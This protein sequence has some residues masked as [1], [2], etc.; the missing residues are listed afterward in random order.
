MPDHLASRRKAQKKPRMNY[1]IETC[2]DRTIREQNRF[3]DHCQLHRVEMT[4]FSTTGA[5]FNGI[6]HDHDRETILFG[7][8]GKNATPR[9]IVK[10]FVAMIIPREGINLFLEYKGLGT[11]RSKNRKRRFFDAVQKLDGVYQ[12]LPAIELSV[13]L[14]P[15]E[16]GEAISKQ[17]GV[18]KE[19]NGYVGGGDDKS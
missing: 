11:A 10:R 14:K 18:G 13:S 1:A 2:V 6:V 17:Q 9:L 19:G 12:D 4:L 16:P 8:S 15:S 7:G 3:L 5:S